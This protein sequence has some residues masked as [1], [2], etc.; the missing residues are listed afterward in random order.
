MSDA[1]PVT[2][3]LLAA[4]LKDWKFAVDHVSEAGGIDYAEVRYPGA[5]AEDLMD[6]LDAAFRKKLQEPAKPIV[7]QMGDTET[8]AMSCIVA[9]LDDLGSEA[10]RRVMNYLSDRYAGQ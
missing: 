9:A 7:L 8:S 1:V 10:V 2:A 3:A 6:R 4:A 5:L